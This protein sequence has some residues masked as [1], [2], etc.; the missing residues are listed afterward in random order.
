[1]FWGKCYL[2]L[3]EWLCGGGV[4]LAGM[5][6]G[7]PATDHSLKFWGMR[8]LVLPCVSSS[9]LYRSGGQPQTLPKRNR[10]SLSLLILTLTQPHPFTYSLLTQVIPSFS[11]HSLCSRLKGSEPWGKPWGSTWSS[12]IDRLENR[13]VEPSVMNAVREVGKVLW[14][15]R[16]RAPATVGWED[17]RLSGG[18]GPWSRQYEEREVYFGLQR[19]RFLHSLL[20]ASSLCLL[21]YIKLF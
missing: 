2:F 9:T 3:L 1:M 5:P 7:R 20:F 10:A 4:A 18:G 6:K 8:S 12:T 21:E 19:S 11:Q 14:V 17:R 13:Q 15:H 16:V